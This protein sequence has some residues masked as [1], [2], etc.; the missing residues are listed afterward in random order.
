MRLHRVYTDN[1]V[2]RYLNRW[3]ELIPFGSRRTVQE[4]EVH[5]S[6]ICF[7]CAFVQMVFGSSA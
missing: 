3:V 7:I 1:L 4:F 5:M 6:F 2:E